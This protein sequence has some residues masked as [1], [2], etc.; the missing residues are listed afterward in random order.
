LPLGPGGARQIGEQR[1]K[2]RLE[3]G[4]HGLI[5]PLVEL[6]PGEA[7]GRKM[8]AERRNR[9]IPLSIPDPYGP[10]RSSPAAERLRR[11][12]PYPYLM[13]GKTAGSAWG[14]I[15]HKSA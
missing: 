12:R 3:S 5:D 9:G 4:L 14:L 1:L 11:R 2:I 15:R 10:G 7:P 13:N 8:V 6:L